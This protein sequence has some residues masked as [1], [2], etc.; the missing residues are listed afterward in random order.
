MTEPTL[1]SL[2]RYCCATKRQALADALTA[3]DTY[4]PASIKE[5][6]REA[7]KV[8]IEEEFKDAE[9]MIDALG[10]VNGALHDILLEKPLKPGGRIELQMR[11]EIVKEVAFRKGMKL[12]NERPPWMPIQ[13]AICSE[14]IDLAAVNDY[15]EVKCEEPVPPDL[16]PVTYIHKKCRDEM[17]KLKMEHAA[18]IERMEKENRT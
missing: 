10:H 6:V 11:C 13:C 16:P 3:V 18:H 14:A 15:F 17:V 12:M 4:A 9:L 1:D 7:M 5:H 2:I 8:A